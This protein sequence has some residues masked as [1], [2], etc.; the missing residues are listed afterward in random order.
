MVKMHGTGAAA[1]MPSTNVPAGGLVNIN[2]PY[3]AT[4]YRNPLLQ[5]EMGTA[6]PPNGIWACAVGV[7]PANNETSIS[8]A[9]TI[10]FM[11][12]VYH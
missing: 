7:N 8:V 2:M 1:A 11:E 6:N 12:E 9:I 3:G 10:C 5:G 4:R